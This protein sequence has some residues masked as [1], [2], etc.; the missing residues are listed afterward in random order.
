MDNHLQNNQQYNT[1]FVL[2]NGQSRLRLNLNEL[3][4][5]G[6]VY[7]C[8]ALYREF[9]PDHLIAVDE[10]MIREIEQSGY[11]LK[12]PVWTN[13][14]KGVLKIPG[15]NLFK[16]HKGWSSGPT[17]LW[18]ASTNKHTTIYIFGFDY[19]GIEKKVNNIYADTQNYKRST[20]AA[21]YFGNWLSQTENVIKSNNNIEFVRVIESGNFI[22]PTLTQLTSNF[23]HM[24]YEDFFKIFP[25][26]I[27]K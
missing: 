10:K 24:I 25:G 22:P 12:N 19:Q 15:L 27:F 1:A 18:L 8:N 11:H 14:N 13:P 3:K 17:A 2:G 23:K 20:D 26:T 4:H 9:T 21:T 7:G 5:H 16:P 6:T